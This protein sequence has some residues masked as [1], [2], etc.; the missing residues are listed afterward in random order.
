ML[1]SAW[2]WELK[3]D[4]FHSRWESVQ[5][6]RPFVRILAI[7]WQEYCHQEKTCLHFLFCLFVCFANVF[8]QNGQ[9]KHSINSDLLD[10][11]FI[12][13]FLSKE[14]H[15]KQKSIL[16]CVYGYR[17]VQ[18]IWTG[19]FWGEGG[20]GGV[21]SRSFGTPPFLLTQRH[22]HHT[23]VHIMHAAHEHATQ[24]T[25]PWGAFWSPAVCIFP[26]S[27]ECPWR[28]W[29][30]RPWSQAWHWQG[31]WAWRVPSSCVGSPPPWH[32]AQQCRSGQ[33]FLHFSRLNT[34]K[35]S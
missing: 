23:H 2:Q 25:K 14:H 11:P 15:L 33:C 5:N 4:M 24:T 19:F 29:P 9:S 18:R 35:V 28:C 31:R 10:T 13:C 27:S 8:E 17:G 16:A 12:N 32:S 7:H 20:W 22:P 26:R 34:G 6:K 30:V 21:H 3:S 1:L